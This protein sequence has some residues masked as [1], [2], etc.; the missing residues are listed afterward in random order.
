MRNR[1]V[2]DKNVFYYIVVSVLLSR[3][4]MYIWHGI[5]MESWNLDLFF[6]RLNKYDAGWYAKIVNYGYNLPPLQDGQ[7]N[8]A[9]FPLFPLI[10]RLLHRIMPIDIWI[11]G[12]SVSTIFLAIAMVVLYKYIILTREDEKVGKVIVYFYCFGVFSFYS[13][14]MYSESLY[15]LLLISCY[16]FMKREQY[17]K[18]GICGCLLSMTRNTGILFVFAILVYWIQKFR[19]EST[20]KSIKAFVTKTLYKYNLILG[21]CLVPLGL[22]SY[23]IYLKMTLG[24]A[25]A[26]IHVQTAWWR[27]NGNMLRN[28]WNALFEN[29]PPSYLGVSA[30]VVLILIGILLFKHKRIDE[31]I[32]P[33]LIFFISGSS[34]LGSVP[35]YMWGSIFVLLT[36]TDE[37]MSVKRK[38]IRIICYASSFVLELSFLSGWFHENSLLI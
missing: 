14:S 6:A 8:W 33:L 27:E 2:I 24:D 3:F 34:S 20:D 35:R 38:Y 21:T 25:L 37:I 12:S 26:F 22:F 19:S 31:A 9:F 28:F 5:I 16:Y 1:E 29:F 36:F 32:M 17:V 18:M 7:A 15:M 10:V 11:L 4:I 30:L 13:S 23:M